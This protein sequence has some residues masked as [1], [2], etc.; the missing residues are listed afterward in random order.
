MDT[1]PRSALKLELVFTA[2]T[3]YCH[4]TTG[5]LSRSKYIR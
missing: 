5:N 3:F 2:R 4:N 1:E